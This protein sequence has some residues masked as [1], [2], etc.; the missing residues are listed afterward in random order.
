MLFRSLI[1]PGNIK[2]TLALDPSGDSFSGTFTITQ[3][4]ENGN[5]LGHVQG[6]IAGTRID[7]N[8][9]ADSIF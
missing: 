9:K 8:T 3:Y 7:T 5:K 2:E 6:N 4:D 1:G